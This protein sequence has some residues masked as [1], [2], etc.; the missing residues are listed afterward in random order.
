MEQPAVIEKQLKL[1]TSA[2]NQ[3]TGVHVKESTTIEQML[4]SS[5]A[6]FHSAAVKPQNQWD[7]GPSVN[8][9]IEEVSNISQ[10]FSG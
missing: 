9:L 7:R 8:N 1:A 10:I 2:H 5:I 6:Q 4:M 3:T